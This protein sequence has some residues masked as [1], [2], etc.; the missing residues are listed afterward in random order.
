MTEINVWYR[1]K[2][3][4]DKRPNCYN[5]VVRLDQKHSCHMMVHFGQL[6]QLDLVDYLV[7]SDKLYP[8]NDKNIV[9]EADNIILPVIAKKLL[10]NKRLKGIYKIM[11]GKIEKE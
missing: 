3:Y 4:S 11:N 8:N 2:S 5:G 9:S 7:S 1:Y 6:V 10:T